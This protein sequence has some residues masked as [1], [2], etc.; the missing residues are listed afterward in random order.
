M[1]EK[2]NRERVRF[3]VY[4]PQVLVIQGWFE[5]DKRGKER[6]FAQ[7]DKKQVSLKATTQQGIE[8]RKKY[9]RYKTDIDV[10]YFLWI[11]LPEKGR[12]LKVFHE[13][14]DGGK[15][16]IYKSSLDALAKKRRRMDSWAEALTA[17]PEGLA[18]RG[19]YIL[20]LIHI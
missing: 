1:S 13:R 16:L 2:F 17:S 19:W 20:S 18:L 3:H 11:R 14:T 15:D 4:E 7:V 5:G 10:E 8:V 6:F 9:L 12:E